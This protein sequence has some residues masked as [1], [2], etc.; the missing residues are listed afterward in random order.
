MSTYFKSFV[1]AML[2]A[3]LFASVSSGADYR[4]YNNKAWA[5]SGRM[6]SS[7]SMRMYRATPARTFA[8]SIVRFAPASGVIAQA[9]SERRLFS[10]EPSMS[11]DMANGCVGGGCCR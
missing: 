6:S 11:T 1:F 2:S 9:P 8:P 5:Q 3:G 10:Y 4:N 7:R